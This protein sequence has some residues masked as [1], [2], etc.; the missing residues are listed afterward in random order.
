MSFFSGL[1]GGLGAAGGGYA[2]A[3]EKLRAQEATD[4]QDAAENKWR[5]EESVRRSNEEQSRVAANQEYRMAQTERQG[6]Q[7]EFAATARASTAAH[8]EQV[9]AGQVTDRAATAQYRRDALAQQGPSPPEDE[10]VVGS[11]R[12]LE[13]AGMNEAAARAHIME[14]YADNPPAL[15][16]YIK[17]LD[18]HSAQFIAQEMEARTQGMASDDMAMYSALNPDASPDDM[19]QL[20]GGGGLP[21]GFFNQ[22]P[23]PGGGATRFPGA[24]QTQGPP[25]SGAALSIPASAGPGAMPAALPYSTAGPRRGQGPGPGPGV[26]TLG[27]PTP[28]EIVAEQQRRRALRG[29]A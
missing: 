1:I 27:T 20:M 6:R 5:E 25:S 21:Q 9:L 19:Q 23:P 8:Q 18:Y 13:N 10:F 12:I 28:Q 4:Q 15:R 16:G 29:P 17:G 14:Q 3:L 7:D 2:Q 11:Y 24:W 26:G 22:P